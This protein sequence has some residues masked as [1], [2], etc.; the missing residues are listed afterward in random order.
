MLKKLLYC[1]FGPLETAFVQPVDKY[2][3][4]HVFNN[5][6]TMMRA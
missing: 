1:P 6:H 2:L 3:L 4:L 5:L